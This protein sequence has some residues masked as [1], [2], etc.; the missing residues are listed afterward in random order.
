MDLDL[1]E[2]ARRAASSAFGVAFSQ[3][4]RLLRLQGGLLPGV[5]P[6]GLIAQRALVHEGL[7][8]PFRLEID[9]LSP[10]AGLPVAAWPG[11][12][13]VLQLLCADGSL[14]SWHGHV[15]AARF[16]GADGGWA[17]YHLTVGPWLSLLHAR[18]DSFVYQGR[19]ALDIVAEVLRDHP[20]ARWRA[21]VQRA[22]RV[23][24][25][26][27]QY[28][29]SDAAFIERLLA[30]EGLVYHFEHH[31]AHGETPAQHVMVI[32]DAQA[33]AP[34]LGALPF[35]RGDL[36]LGPQAREAVHGAAVHHHGAATE[37]V[38]GSWSPQHL[39]GTTAQDTIAQ[40]T[41]AAPSRPHWPALAVYDGAGQQRYADAAH[42]HEQAR[43]RAQALAWPQQGLHARSSVR[44]LVPGALIE[45]GAHAAL[46]GRRWRLTRVRHH[47]TN[48]LPAPPPGAAAAA[49]QDDAAGGGY[50]NE[51]EACAAEHPW[52]PPWTPKPQAPGVQAAVVTGVDGAALHTERNARVKIQFPW[53]RGVRPLP[54]GL[55][56]DSPVDAQGHAPGD[57][58]ASAWVRVTQGAAG[59][60]WGTVFVPRVGTEV[61]VDFVEGDIDRPVIVGQLYNECDAPPYAAGQD[62]GVNHPGTISG[63]LS[64]GLDGGHHNS[65]VL[66]DATGQLRMRF[67]CTHTMSELGL[68][69]LIEQAACGA[70][71]GPWRGAGFELASAGWTMV[72]AA[73]GLLLSTTARPA[74]GQ[75]VHG[76]QMD[77][78][79][80]QAQW[81]GAHALHQR[82]HQAASACQPA[83][84]PAVWTQAVQQVEP[85]STEQAA[86]SGFAQPLMVWDAAAGAV[87]STEGP[88]VSWAAGDQHWVAQDD[89]QLSAAHTA[90]ITAGA[91]LR[92]YAHDQGLQF[93]A[94]AGPLSMRAHTDSLSVQAEREATLTSTDDEIHIQAQERIELASGAARIVLDGPHITFTCPGAFTVH[95]A[96]H[97][98][99]AGLSEPALL[100]HLPTGLVQVPEATAQVRLAYHDG[101]PVQGASV[102]ARSADGTVHRTQLDV[103]GFAQID[104]LRGAM[105]ELTVGP[106]IRPYGRFKLPARCDEDLQHWNTGAA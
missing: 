70:Q 57:E 61:L 91:A 41:A 38:L 29:E 92:W 21:Q 89:V 33:P 66:D 98:W 79:E 30:E 81:R 9:A 52:V 36:R 42:A 48:P 76:A 15:L 78:P 93:K 55:A 50:H 102:L 60:N 18:R 7:S 20:Q 68:G 27:C 101:E 100:P 84:A 49:A 35:G 47:I 73:Q 24:E 37:V 13:V 56:H 94:A 34:D 26:C 59:P 63:W 3:S 23:R 32:T 19:H 87:F 54:G 69:H 17:R 6:A 95:A 44:R 77:T 46:Q 74:L 88:L 72:R 22:L 99:G 85:P 80:A 25:L 12:E 2:A 53:Q 10:S 105:V 106:D 51:F 11:H 40:D 1:A 97:D 8:E 82:L 104:G 45:I 43:R 64:H 14:R 62:S 4:T 103:Q 28:R 83:Q 16:G 90:S 31:D 65:W 75:S 39:A 96:T 71:R 86:A 5:L 58:R 67:L